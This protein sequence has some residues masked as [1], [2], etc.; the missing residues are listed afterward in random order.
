MGLFCVAVIFVGCI[1]SAD[2]G[3]LLS[4]AGPCNLQF[5]GDHG[6]HPAYR[7]E[8]WYY[9]GNVRSENGLPY[10]YQLTFFRVRLE[11]TD[12]ADRWPLPP[13]AW[14]TRQIYMSHAAVSDLSAQRH[15][16]A[17]LAARN[18]LDMAGAVQTPTETIVH[19]K[20]WSV[21][22]GPDAHRLRAEA[23]AFSFHLALRPVKKPVLHGDRGYSRKGS[24]VTQASCYYSFTRLETQGDLVVKGEKRAVSGFSWM[25]HEYSTA[26]VEDGIVGWD[27]FCF[28]MDDGTDIMLYRLRLEDGQMHSASSG[29]I[30]DVEGKATHL[31]SGSFRL[32]PVDTWQ[33][34]VSG[35]RYPMRWTVEIFPLSMMLTVASSLDDQEMQTPGTTNETYWEGSVRVDGQAGSRRVKGRGYVEMTGYA[36]PFGTAL[37]D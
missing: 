21:C 11:S 22:I 30:L 17:E 23:P 2:E 13:S 28:Q 7:T 15:F 33:S 19:V 34:P 20:N 35:A 9:T 27:W 29:T 1:G 8:W 5:P 32:T 37:Y 24:L 6:A 25:D 14:R 31:S 36:K 10:G 12:T 26:P 18:A 3:P 4:V 16:H